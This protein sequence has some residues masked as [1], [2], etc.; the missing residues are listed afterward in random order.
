[1]AERALLPPRLRDWEEGKRQTGV[2][3]RT[4]RGSVVQ[5]TRHDASK[6]EQEVLFAVVSGA[7]D[8]IP[9]RLQAEVRTALRMLS[10]EDS[11]ERDPLGVCTPLHTSIGKVRP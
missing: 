9:V 11:G 6:F 5:A 8:R 7:I 3:I 1:M 2:F 4:R 10:L